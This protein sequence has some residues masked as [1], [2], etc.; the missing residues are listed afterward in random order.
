[1]VGYFFISSQTVD[2]FL[3]S[4]PQKPHFHLILIIKTTSVAIGYNTNNNLISSLK[5]KVNN[6][7]MRLDDGGYYFPYYSNIR[8]F[9][10]DYGGVVKKGKYNHS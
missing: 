9:F 8:E 2:D 7:L 4:T 5:M 10:Q 6:E 1:M 3:S